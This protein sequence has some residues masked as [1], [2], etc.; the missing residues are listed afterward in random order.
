MVTLAQRAKKRLTHLRNGDTK[1][2]QSPQTTLN[3]VEKLTTLLF[4]SPFGILAYYFGYDFVRIQ[5][6]NWTKLDKMR[7]FI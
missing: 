1:K 2:E 4:Y 5:S 7:V 3:I 6:L